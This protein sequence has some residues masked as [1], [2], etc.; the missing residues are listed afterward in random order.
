MLSLGLTDIR[1][2]YSSDID[3]LKKTRILREILVPSTRL[4]NPLCTRQSVKMNLYI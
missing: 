3:W 2:L 4:K 1:D